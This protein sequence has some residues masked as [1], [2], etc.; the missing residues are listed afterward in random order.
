[1][2]QQLFTTQGE[3]LAGEAWS[4]YP[5]PQMKRDSYMNLNGKWAFGTAPKG[6]DRTIQVPFCPESTL[7]GIG[8]HFPEGKGLYYR[9]K[10]TLPELFV[11]F[12]W[13]FSFFVIIF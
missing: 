12:C 7:S 11:F 5:R 2:L 9:R 10:I 8:E 1:M 4:V 3:N 6:L 13:F